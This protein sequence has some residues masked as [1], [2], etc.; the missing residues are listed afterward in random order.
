MNP[1]EQQCIIDLCRSILATMAHGGDAQAQL[2]ALCRLQ[3]QAS[4]SS[5][6]ALM[7]PT[8]RGRGLRVLAAPSLPSRMA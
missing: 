4:P 6:A 5:L 1:T 8:H 2:D 7:I 3:E